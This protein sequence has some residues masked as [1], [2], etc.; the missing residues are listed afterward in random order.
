ITEGIHGRRL[1]L[2]KWIADDN[3]PLTLRSIVNRVWQG[4]FGIGLSAT[5]NNFGV[6][7]AKP[8]HPQLL[9]YLASS[10]VRNGWSIKWLHKTIMT[11][12]TYRQSAEHPDLDR[13]QTADP[14]NHLLA[15]FPPRRLTAEELRD[16]LLAVTGELNPEMGGLPIRPEIN[17]E[18]ALQPRMI[19]FSLAPS[20]QPSPTPK[21]RNRRTIY[22]YRTRGQADPFLEVFN[23]PNPNESCEVRNA[24]SVS[25]QAFTLMNSD[26][27][28][29]RSIAFALRV[30]KEAKAPAGQI[31]RAFQLALGRN[32]DKAESQRLL[33]FYRDMIE[34]HTTHLPEP[35][36]Y[37]TRLTQSLVEEFS[38]KPFDYN[39]ILPIL[40]DYT[41]DTKPEDVDPETRAMADI[42]LLLFN[43][44]EF[45]YVY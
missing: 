23:K 12:A 16:S 6:K 45:V 25:P 42:C 29:D 35:V 41:P 33:S 31:R 27:M 14:N 5:A 9:D 32:P 30:Q 18:V 15:H 44:N 37:P 1:T 3:N 36:V 10:F 39:E 19:Q 13:L 26:I 20:Y 24:A 40:R 28:T 43:A 17:M 11:S 4:H 8:T 22:A 7:G 38:G 21:Q 2:A 34:H